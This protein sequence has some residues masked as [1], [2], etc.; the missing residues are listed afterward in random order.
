M[1][2]RFAQFDKRHNSNKSAG[3]ENIS[4][5]SGDHCTGFVGEETWELCFGRSQACLDVWFFTRLGLPWQTRRSLGLMSLRLAF[6]TGE[7]RRATNYTQIHTRK[8]QFTLH[9]TGENATWLL[10]GRCLFLDNM[11]KYK[12]RPRKESWCGAYILKF[13]SCSNP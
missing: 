1:Q 12:G 5:L 7:Q 13:S 8:G 2:K 10:F 11:S 9:I 3:K 6:H 4:Q